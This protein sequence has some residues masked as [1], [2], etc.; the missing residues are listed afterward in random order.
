MTAHVAFDSLVAR[1]GGRLSLQRQLLYELGVR[2]TRPPREL[3][4]RDP[5]GYVRLLAR[6][7]QAAELTAVAGL[8]GFTLSCA[9]RD[10]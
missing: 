2:G 1:T 3:A 5:R 8:G 9:N 4:S 7:S 6:A 10:E